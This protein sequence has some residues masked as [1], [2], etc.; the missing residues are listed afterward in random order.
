MPR[1]IDIRTMAQEEFDKNIL[2]YNMT[3]R[4]SLGLVIPL[5]DF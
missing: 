4:K 2:N 5:E 3:P 1:Y